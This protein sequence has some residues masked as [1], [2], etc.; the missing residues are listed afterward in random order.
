MIYLDYLIQLII[1][2]LIIILIEAIIHRIIKAYAD[3]LNLELDFVRKIIMKRF[4]SIT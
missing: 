1:C 2:I 3:K 4:P